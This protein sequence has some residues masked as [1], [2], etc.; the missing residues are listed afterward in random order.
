[1]TITRVTMFKLNEED[2]E[3]VLA[4]YEV[5][6]ADSAK[7]GKPYMVSV[8]ARRIYDDPRNQGF[9]LASHTTFANLEDMKYYDE[10]DAAHDALR[11]VVKPLVKGPPMTV[12][13]DS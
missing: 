2:I 11:Q 3:K 12:Y 9:T 1:M 5:M 4:Q 7:D 10:G 13:W 8:N 6:K